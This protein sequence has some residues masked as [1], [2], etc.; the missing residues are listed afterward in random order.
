[1]KTSSRPEAWENASDK[2]AIVFSFAS[3]WL[4]DGSSFFT[5]HRVKLCKTKGVPYYF[6]HSIENCFDPVIAVFFCM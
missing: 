2:V 5:R 6:R 3:D 1:M 4:K